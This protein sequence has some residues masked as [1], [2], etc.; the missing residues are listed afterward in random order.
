MTAAAALGA[1]QEV[2][3]VVVVVLAVAAR[4]RPGPRRLLTERRRWFLLRPRPLEARPTD[5]ETKTPRG[6]RARSKG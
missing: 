5:V 1:L 4:S 3:V 2:A 6:R